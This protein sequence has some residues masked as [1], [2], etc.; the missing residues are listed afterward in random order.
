MES[1]LDDVEV[2]DIS[3]G[4]HRNEGQARHLRKPTQLV[5]ISASFRK[6]HCPIVER[7][8]VGLMRHGRNAGKLMAVRIVKH[9]GAH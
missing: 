3:L 7:L 9:T 2:S 6:A 5:D 4:L 1:G 8:A